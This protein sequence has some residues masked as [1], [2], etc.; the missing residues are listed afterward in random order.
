L[1]SFAC[2]RQVISLA[3]KKYKSMSFLL[4]RRLALTRSSVPNVGV[5]RWRCRLF[6]TDAS[7]TSS[8]SQSAAPKPEPKLPTPKAKSVVPPTP[9]VDAKTA[10]STKNVGVGVTSDSITGRIMLREMAKYI[11]PKGE[12]GTKLRVVGALG[13]L[14]ASKVWPDDDSV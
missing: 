1:Q 11:W 6:S 4:V 14:I 5:A 7:S 10:T 13:L 8:G 2:S 3:H 12:Y 9:T